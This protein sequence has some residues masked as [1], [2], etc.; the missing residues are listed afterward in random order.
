MLA[1]TPAALALLR[2]HSATTTN[3]DYPRQTPVQQLLT[4]PV[5]RRANP[6]HAYRVRLLGAVNTSTVKYP[7]SKRLM[8]ESNSNAVGAGA[9]LIYTVEH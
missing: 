9:D 5:R 4:G 8:F 7:L 1:K 6:G 3:R 2:S